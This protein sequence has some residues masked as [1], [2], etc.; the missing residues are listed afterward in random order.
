MGPPPWAYRWVRTPNKKNPSPYKGRQGGDGLAHTPLPHKKEKRR[1]EYNHER[2]E[3]IFCS[4]FIVVLCAV[5]IN[6]QAKGK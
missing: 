3:F 6:K 2:I 4:F 5:I 1:Q